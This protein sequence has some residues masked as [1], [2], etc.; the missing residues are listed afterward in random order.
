M[1]VVTV[2]VATGAASL[3]GAA[4]DALDSTYTQA[5]I[6][7]A[8]S[9]ISSPTGSGSVLGVWRYNG[10]TYAFRN[11]AGGTACDMFE[12]SS[13][14]WSQ[15]T[16]GNT[17]DFTAG[18]TAFA[19]G[20]TL[21]GGTS[22]A[23][24]IISNV[25]VTSGDWST[26]D[27][28]GYL[29]IGTVTGGPYQAETG[30]SVSGS[31]TIA[32]EAAITLQPSGRFDFVNNNFGGS[33][34]SVKMYG[35]DGVSEGFEWD[36]TVFTPIRT[37]MS[38]D[39]PTRVFAHKKHLVYAYPG[40]SLQ[41]SGIGTPYVWT[42]LSGAAE[43]GL[44]DEIT[45][46]INAA[47]VLGIYTKRTTSFLYGSSAADWE[48]KTLSQESGAHDWTMQEVAGK[49]VHTDAAGVRDLSA[50]TAYGDFDIGRMS[51]LT[52][53]WFDT[54]K[55]TGGSL[56]ATT[57]VKAKNQYRIFYDNGSGMTMDMSKGV[58]EFVPFNLGITV[59]CACS[60]EDD[61]GTEWVL[62]GA[63]NGYVYRLDVGT[64]FDGSA[65]TAYVR[66]SFNSVKSHSYN[67]RF[68]KA[69]L[70]LEAGP[71]T[72][73]KI[74]AD[75]AYGDPNAPSQIEESFTVSGGG[76][77]WGEANWNEF[78]W[79]S[80]AEGLADADIDGFGNNVSIVLASEATYEE[81]HTLHG[82]TIYYSDRGLKR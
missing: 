62:V 59:T 40:G 56:A 76:G 38:T 34:G 7:A 46:F 63:S 13:S 81:P 78:Y 58:A 65:V 26:N 55:T 51:F 77:F 61:D 67:K 79:S 57:R 54:V 49:Y 60:V 66:F 48:L 44:G 72:V 28:V 75:F 5:A 3:S 30:T 17:V 64:S 29:V 20:E 19:V 69:L 18:T 2:G 68:H 52:D 47:G 25:V 73:V 24:S 12:S 70:E 8:R 39:T 9:L 4:T 35:V 22:G 15:I 71:S 82:M 45:G 50:T 31:A 10:K 36:G 74:S 32:A 41:H 16:L 21:T 80:Q 53:P 23:T 42:L 33:A 1:S 6:E 14:G 37:G 43:I 11:N 27:A